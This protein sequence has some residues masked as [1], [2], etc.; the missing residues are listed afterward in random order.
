MS[1]TERV[2]A[3]TPGVRYP[4]HENL[5]LM[6]RAMPRYNAWVY[7]L[8][9]PHVGSRILEAGCG[10]GAF[11]PMLLEHG[12]VVAVDVE[13]AFTRRV[14]E[15]FSG[16]GRLS[17]ETLSLAGPDLLRFEAGAFDTVVCL[18][19]LEH[20]E[21]DVETL[22]HFHRLLMR[23]GKLLLQVPAFSWLFGTIDE[24]SEHK[25]RYTRGMLADRLRSVGFSVDVLRY[26]NGPGVFPWF[27]HGRVLRLD[28]HPAAEL[29]LWDR[30]VPFLSV[31]E[32]L[33]PPP[34]GLSV[35]AVGRR[36]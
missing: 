8:L 11:T 25:R 15:Q 19:V 30:L 2:G 14:R 17:V 13:P 34:I 3:T 29:S 6:Q 9:K 1:P 32:R 23:G 10:V 36:P 20:V 18:N 12:T 16:D 7:S 21:D 27:M 22:A 33:L 5:D 4:A 35:I 28:K 26:M 24:I 31:F